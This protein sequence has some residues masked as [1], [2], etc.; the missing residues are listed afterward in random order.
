MEVNSDFRELLQAFNEGGVR[1]LIVGGLALAFHDQP[2]FTKDID[3][4]VEP[5]PDNAVRVYHALA[6]FGAPLD[7]VT[8][9]D[10]SKEDVVFQIGVAP[11]R[12]D[13][14][15]SITGVTF[16]EAYPSREASS[17]GDV[18][19]NVLGRADLIA[20]KR[21]TARPQDLV[22]LDNLLAK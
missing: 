13:V 22:D 21:A 12:V 19:V 20:N 2:R 14:M 3:V 11:L 16:K 8:S 7:K 10:F 4:W 1:Y 9:E 5:T 15:T 6:S 18:P 17:Y